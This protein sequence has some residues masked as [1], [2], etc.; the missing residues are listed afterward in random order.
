MAA[1]FAATDNLSFCVYEKQFM[2]LW[3]AL[4]CEVLESNPG[5]GQNKFCHTRYVLIAFLGKPRYE[6][7]TDGFFISPYL[8]G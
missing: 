3:T 4:G 1:E 5:L 7:K 8:P 6:I 2:Q